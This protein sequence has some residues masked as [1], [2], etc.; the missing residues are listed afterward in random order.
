MDGRFWRFWIFITFLFYQL[1]TA[2]VN[3]PFR[4]DGLLVSYSANLEVACNYP[5]IKI[6]LLWFIKHHYSK[7]LV[8]LKHYTLKFIWLALTSVFSCENQSGIKVITRLRVNLSHVREHEFQHGFQDSWNPNSQLRFWYWINFSLCFPLSHKEWLCWCSEFFWSVFS[9]FELN[10]Q[11]KYV[12]N[13]WDLWKSWLDFTNLEWWPFLYSTL[14][15]R[16][17]DES[18]CNSPSLKTI[19]F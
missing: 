4:V 1:S 2:I 13:P 9:A 10:I 14:P 19:F 16:F 3:F 12:K 17:T 6:L 15:N 11:S 7:G 18:N 8:F 5:Y